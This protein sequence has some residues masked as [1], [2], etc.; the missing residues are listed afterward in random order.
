MGI[1]NLF[2]ADRPRQALYNFGQGAGELL[3]GQGGM[4]SLGRMIPGATGALLA[5]ILGPA[6]GL[7]GGGLAQ[8]IGSTIGGEAYDAPS[9]ADL[10]ALLGGDPTDAMQVTGVNMA[11][12]PMNWLGA[13]MASRGIGQMG[14]ALSQ[15]MPSI[16]GGAGMLGMGADAMR[17]SGAGSL[18][19]AMGLGVNAGDDLISGAFAQTGQKPSDLSPAYEAYQRKMQQRAAMGG[20][21][22]PGPQGGG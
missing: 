14:G 7:L 4:T 10:V 21:P 15:G 2:G 13:A 16:P 22:M 12:D 8:K 19:A 11:T 1:S 17:T 3:S 18:M 20:M 5:A 9:A 6:A